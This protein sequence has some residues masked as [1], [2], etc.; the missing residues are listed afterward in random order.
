MTGVGASTAGSLT[1][2][3]YGALGQVVVTGQP[4]TGGPQIHSTHRQI[5]PVANI[6]TNLCFATQKYSQPSDRMN[7]S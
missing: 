5:G 6:Q 4:L 3:R 1:R 2:P 7:F